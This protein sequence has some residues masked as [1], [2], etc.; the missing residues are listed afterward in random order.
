MQSQPNSLGTVVINPAAGELPYLSREE[1]RRNV[2]IAVEC[3]GDKV[4]VFA[5]VL[6]LRTEDAV[7]VAFDAK[8]AGA[9]GIFSHRNIRGY[10]AL[11]IREVP[12]SLDRHA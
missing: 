6:D 5:A 7:R 2:E 12:G 11:G 1:K 10:K 8:L 4:P 9:D 3:C